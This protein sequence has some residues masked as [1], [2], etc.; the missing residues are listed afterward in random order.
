MSLI[1][2]PA[3]PAHDRASQRPQSREVGAPIRI[4]IGLALAPNTHRAYSHAKPKRITGNG[5]RHRRNAG[6]FAVA[7]YWAYLAS[8][9]RI[10]ARA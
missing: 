5:T 9:L 3:S 10:R 8:E 1:A 6:L 2:A 4:Q 7:V